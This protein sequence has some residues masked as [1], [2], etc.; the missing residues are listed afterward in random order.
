M[1]GSGVLPNLLFFSVV[2]FK[3]LTYGQMMFYLETLMQFF[4]KI[5]GT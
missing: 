5:A 2:D 3:D 1:H 4:K